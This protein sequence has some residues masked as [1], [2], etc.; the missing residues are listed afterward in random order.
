VLMQPRFKLTYLARYGRTD[1]GPHRR[2]PAGSAM[3]ETLLSHFQSRKA[4]SL[5][6]HAVAV[7]STILYCTFDL[8]RTHLFGKVRVP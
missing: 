3:S 6:E 2:R 5:V 4:R 1:D 8:G 7:Y